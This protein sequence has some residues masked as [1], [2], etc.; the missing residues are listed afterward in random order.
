[1]L[2]NLPLQII[3]GEYLPLLQREHGLLSAVHSSSVHSAISLAR[4]G[5]GWDDV[6]A[7][8]I[9]RPNRGTWTLAFL[10]ST[11]AFSL[12]VDTTENCDVWL[13][14]TEKPRRG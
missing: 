7:G 10:H 5:I 1:M 6:E 4:V 13:F 14:L 8:G 2:Q 3:A 12:L 11:R 9:P